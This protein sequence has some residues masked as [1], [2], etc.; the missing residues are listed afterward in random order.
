MK[1]SGHCPICR[2]PLRL[3]R[4]A[5]PAC[6]AE[7]PIDEPLSPYDYLSDEYAQFLQAFL[8]CRGNM[9]DVQNKLGIS[10][11]TAKRKLDELLMLLGLSSIEDTEEEF[12][13]SLLKKLI[14]A[15]KKS[16]R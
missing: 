9:K 1:F 7:F 16:L 12:D 2:E 14:E 8:A 13:M 10:Y 5:C 15:A 4:L 6:K 3:A 11:P